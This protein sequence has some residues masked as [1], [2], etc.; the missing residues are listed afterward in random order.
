MLVVDELNEG[1]FVSLI[2]PEELTLIVSNMVR[3]MLGLLVLAGVRD[4]VRVRVL[5]LEDVRVDVL[6]EVGVGVIEGLGVR[7]ELELEDRLI[8]ELDEEVGVVVRLTLFVVEL[9]LEI[10]ADLLGLRDVDNVIE[11]VREEEGGMAI[12]PAKL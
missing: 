1:E 7:L 6:V 3:E 11:G 12:V 9:V 10:E 2:V 5:V 8:E 4:L